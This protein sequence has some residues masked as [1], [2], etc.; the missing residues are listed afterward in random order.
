M[1]GEVQRSCKIITTKPNDLV[2]GV[3]DRMPVILG[4]KNVD[5]WL[6]PEVRD[7]GKLQELLSPFPAAN[8]LSYPVSVAV[9]ND[10]N[11]GTELIDEITL[12]QN[13]THSTQRRG[14]GSYFSV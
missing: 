10:K 4:D 14:S 6:D 12:T 9:G 1:D 11:T 5:I 3:H 8:M 13:K 2:A 7:K